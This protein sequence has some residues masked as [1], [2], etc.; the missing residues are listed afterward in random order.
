MRQTAEID[1]VMVQAL[2]D[3]LDFIPLT[4]E[5]DYAAF[6]ALYLMREPKGVR[7]RHIYARYRAQGGFDIYPRSSVHFGL[8]SG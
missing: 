2:L 1:P 4:Q 6:A 7:A 5:G 8:V 3:S